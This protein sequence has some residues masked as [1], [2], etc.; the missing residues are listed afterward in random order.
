[1]QIKQSNIRFIEPHF[2]IVHIAYDKKRELSWS[3]DLQRFAFR[4]ALS[5][6]DGI[7]YPL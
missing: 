1:M 4:I 6:H 3:C 7:K 5:P 2:T